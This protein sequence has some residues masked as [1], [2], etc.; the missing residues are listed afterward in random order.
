M[1]RPLRT[2][3]NNPDSFGRDIIGAMD[4]Q[5]RLEEGRGLGAGLQESGPIRA[6]NH[7]PGA[8]HD[9]VGDL[10]ASDVAA[11]VLDL[12]LDFSNVFALLGTVGKLGRLRKLS[13]H[14][15]GVAAREA[16]TEADELAELMVA[17]SRRV[18]LGADPRFADV[19]RAVL[20]G[21]SLDTV[22]RLTDIK[23]LDTAVPLGRS[24][25]ATESVETYFG[26]GFNPVRGVDHHVQ[27]TVGAFDRQ[28]IQLAESDPHRVLAHLDE[29]GAR[30][31]L[32]LTAAESEAR[33]AV[34]VSEQL[35]GS[36][37][38]INGSGIAAGLSRIDPGEDSVD[39]WRALL[40]LVDG[41]LRRAPAGVGGVLDREAAKRQVADLIVRLAGNDFAKNMTRPLIVSLGADGFESLTEEEQPSYDDYDFEKLLEEGQLLYE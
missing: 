28:V 19:T 1:G 17:A 15:G 31:Q 35:R 25:L 39:V 11:G 41:N 2:V 3:V 38:E 27:N 29:I 34:R 14:V 23:L 33:E 9:I 18:D 22:Q 4:E 37:W 26:N 21:E 20:A 8:E 7:L 16:L 6:F 30:R 5:A 24:S 13:G 12:T 36:G 32:I 10:S 40:S